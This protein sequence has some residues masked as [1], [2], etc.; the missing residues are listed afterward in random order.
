MVSPKTPF[1]ALDRAIARVLWTGGPRHKGL[2]PG[3]I[4][5]GMSKEA[6]ALLCDLKSADIAPG[7]V[8]NEVAWLGQESEKNRR[9]Q[10]TQ[11]ECLKFDRD[12][13][14]LG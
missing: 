14:R 10:L 9:R 13:L 1:E 12:V 8:P 3:A 2:P 4:I 11:S 5:A 7:R 6:R